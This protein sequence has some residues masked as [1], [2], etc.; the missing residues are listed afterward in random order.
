VA[1]PLGR[2]A[3][4]ITGLTGSEGISQLFR[5][6]LDL[7]AENGREVAFD[8]LLGQKATVSLALGGGKQRYWSGIVSRLSQGMRDH[9]FTSHRAEMVP[10]LWLLTRRVQSRIFQHLSVTDILKQVLQGLDVSFEIRGTFHPRDYCVQYRE[11]DFDFASRLMEEEGIYYYFRHT[12]AGHQ[13]VL[14]NTPHGHPEL[15]EQSQLLFDEVRG[16][17]RPEGRITE[18]EKVQEL[19]SGK[20]TLWDHC[21]ELPG[22]HLEADKVIQESVAVGTVSHKLK[23]AG[24]ERLELYDYPGGYAQRFAGIGSGGSARPAELPKIYEDNKRT[25]DIR[26]QQEALAGLV[27]QGAGSCRQL[28]SGHRFTLARHFNADGQYLITGVEHDVRLGDPTRSGDGVALTYQNRF[29]CIPLALP[30]RPPC[31]TARPRVQG[32]Q[33]AVVVGPP[34][35]EVFTDKYGR[36]KVQ[37]HWDRQG[38]HD[39]DS[40]CWVRVGAPWAGKRRGLIHIPMVGDEVIVDFLEGDP[41]RPIIVG[42]VF[43]AESM[44]PWELPAN[45]TVSGYK[46]R[47]GSNFLKVED[48]APNEKYHLNAENNLEVSVKNHEDHTAKNRKTTIAEGDDLDVKGELSMHGKRVVITGDDEIVLQVKGNEIKINS[49]GIQING[50]PAVRINC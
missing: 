10:Q 50:L 5:F 21:F 17:V 24:N 33:T 42:S 22:K 3:L 32:T 36:V 34:G 4:L 44:P 9:S 25:A 13:L 37:F 49:D 48:K 1:T 30:Y 47:T 39:A 23:V 15:P 8:K 7:L 27:I 45:R 26:M 12:A 41:D 2:D 28:V 16:G 11:S 35:E 31:V 43:N 40:S 19:R 6:Q 38:K 46:G 20:V 14:G 29:T 18:W